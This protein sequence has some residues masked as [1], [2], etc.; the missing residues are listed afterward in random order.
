[1]LNRLLNTRRQDLGE[2]A[3]D[4]LWIDLGSISEQRI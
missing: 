3:L 2:F 4:F 1:M